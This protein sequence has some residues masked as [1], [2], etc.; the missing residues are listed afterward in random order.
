MFDRAARETR[1]TPIQLR[2]A[3]ME[4]LLRPTLTA[5]TLRAWRRG[6]KPVPLAAMLAVCDLA[7]KRPNE[8]ILMLKR[9]GEIDGDD[10]ALLTRL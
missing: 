1:L 3:L 2:G 6:N 10:A 9:D 7:G 8:I 5:P 4:R